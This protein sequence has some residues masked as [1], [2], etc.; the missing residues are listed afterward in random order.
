MTAAW[1]RTIIVLP[2]TVLVFVPALLLYLT[3]YRWPAEARWPW[4]I[5]GGTL[6]VAGLA[7]AR[8][9]MRLF[10]TMGRGTAA[11]WNPPKELVVAGPY[12]HVRNPMITSVLAMLAG[13]AMVM[14][15]GVV[16]IWL[17][18][19]FL[20]NTLYFP[21]V[22]EKGLEKRFGAD[23]ML[24]KANVPRWLPRWSPWSRE[25]LPDFVA[26]LADHVMHEYVAGVPEEYRQGLKEQVEA[27]RTTSIEW[28][29]VG[30][31]A[32]FEIDRTRAKPMPELA[33][34]SPLSVDGTLEN[35]ELI[36][37]LQIY[38]LWFK[39]GYIH[40]LE[41]VVCGER[42]PAIAPDEAKYTFDL[43]A[44]A[45]NRKLRL[46]KMQA[47]AEQPHGTA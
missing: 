28:T 39:D 42:F 36:D 15:S 2:G 26:P 32:N 33:L 13:E 10:A 38:L 17:G 11:P 8:W 29:V 24:Y 22:E 5:V 20:G 34:S 16:G 6:I 1:I 19:F 46:E 44:F 7:L 31:Y 27:S 47:D 4:W 12:R 3:D 35:A 21:L 23:Y 30:F 45:M 25:P 40:C 18:V 43:A 37:A 9:T 14:G 41:G